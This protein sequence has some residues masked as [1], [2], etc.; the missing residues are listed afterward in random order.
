MR[1]NINMYIVVSIFDRCM[2]IS[3]VA[4]SNL[5]RDTRPFIF[6]NGTFP[7]YP[8]Q[9]TG[10]C[11]CYVIVVVR[12]E[13]NTC[14]VAAFC[15]AMRNHYIIMMINVISVISLKPFDINRLLN[16]FIISISVTGWSKALAFCN[17]GCWFESHW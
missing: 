4:P 9:R 1:Q 15:H 7:V 17:E 12:A 13:I 10:A 5:Y 14:R 6:Y 8:Q 16:T 3:F 11:K 2:L